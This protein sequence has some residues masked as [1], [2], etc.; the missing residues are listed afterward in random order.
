MKQLDIQRTWQ[1][2]GAIHQIRA[3]DV[4]SVRGDEFCSNVTC[5]RMDYLRVA[6]VKSVSLDMHH[7]THY[8]GLIRM[9][10]KMHVGL[11]TDTFLPIVDGVGRVVFA[12]AET[13]S[14]MKHQVTVSSPMY[15]TGFRGGF[16]FDLIDYS[17][18][19]VPTV[20]QYRM[21]SP[22]IDSHYRKRIGMTVL[23]IAHAHSPFSAGSEALR[24]GRDKNIP[25]IGSFHSK[26]YDDFYKVTKNKTLSKL[27][28][29]T[30]VSFYNRCDQVWAVSS[31]TAEVLESYGYK[32]PIVVMPNGVMLRSVN[33]S[34][35]E[36]VEM[37]YALHDLP[38][39]LFV[40]QIDWKKN[41]LRVLEA[42]ARLNQE[43]YL[44]RLLLAGQGPDEREVSKKV[45]E[46]GLGD[47]AFLVGHITSTELLDALYSRASIFTFPS[48]YDN[49]PMVGREA[50]VMATPAVLIRG[51]SAAEI[52]SDGK[53]GFLCR[54]DSD[55][56]FMVLKEAL[57]D[58]DRTKSIGRAA[59]ESIPMAWQDIM[60]RALEQYQALI[61]SFNYR[62]KRR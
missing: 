48:L 15:E 17:A 23:D 62:K 37:K 61:D 32:G 40:G 38:M 56:L 58:P 12:Y 42:A 30:V 46:L 55:D 28:V 44:F 3:K 16:P 54:D 57:D 51:S 45:A 25:V 59:Q 35:L 22:A 11:F 31:S 4:K 43:G 33:A 5:I 27:L 9:E 50:A 8:N 20:P 60:V 14:A 7:S 24:A 13:L 34:A 41:I 21:G 2:S 47:I 49:A 53:N 10:V 1:M 29:G 19:R 52:V 18:L 39:L 6:F 36:E 26:Y